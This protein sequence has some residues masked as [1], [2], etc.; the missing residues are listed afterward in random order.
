MGATV[1]L[2]GLVTVE[3]RQ[4][5]QT[6]FDGDGSRRVPVLVCDGFPDH[7]AWIPASLFKA[8]VRQ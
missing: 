2:S 1:V 4:S 8:L 6:N 3:S 5:S 7:I